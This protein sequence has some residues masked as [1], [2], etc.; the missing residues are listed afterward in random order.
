MNILVATS[1]GVAALK[2]PSLMRRLRDAG[3]DVRA[4]A[5][6]DS[7]QFITKLS[8]AIGAGAE[9]FD[10]EAW[11]K[12]DGHAR[13]IELARWAQ[14][15]I[16][17]PASADALASAAQGRGDDV[18][19]ALILAG[20]SK[21]IWVPAMNTVMWQHPAVKANIETLKSYGHRFLGPVFGQLAAKGEG[22]G[23]GRMMEIEDI[24]SYFA[25]LLTP[26]DLKGKKVLVSAGPTR[27]YI[28]PVRF[29][30]NP[31]S[32][33]MGYAVA[34]VAFFR[35]AEV[36]LVSGPANLVAPEG[37]KLIKVESAQ[38][39]LEALDGEFDSSDILVMTAAVADWRSA[40]IKQE[41]Q[42]KMGERQQLE[43]IRTKDILLHLSQRKAKQVVV[44]F[45]METHQGVE[46]AADKARL[47][48][49]DFICLNYPTR[50]GS[51]FGGD[52]NEVSIVE[53]DEGV[54]HLARMS[55]REIASLILDKALSYV[56]N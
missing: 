24:A 50:E 21:V 3:H 32:G 2:T 47:K 7:Y 4:V 45:A 43:L 41:K 12:A 10:R 37:V 28:D 31:S 36:T 22:A 14:V 17:A 51:A 30:S 20:V 34:E 15:M 8:L 25:Y 53:P 13:H 1:G 42:A 48:K 19:S 23:M 44:G 27:E 38:S 52:S 29:I 11:F 56:S 46:R 54:Q 9:V 49:M 33:K 35:G 39:M 26:K 5:T 18:I 16:V 6:D 55:K 40:E